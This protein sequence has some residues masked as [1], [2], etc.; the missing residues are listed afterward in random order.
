MPKPTESNT[1]VELP[2]KPVFNPVAKPSSQQVNINIEPD[3]SISTETNKSHN[4]GD[5]Y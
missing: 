4:R 3:F 1:I 2:N 5:S